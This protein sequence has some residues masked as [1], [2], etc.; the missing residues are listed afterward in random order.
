MLQTGVLV[1]IDSM[2]RPHKRH[3]AV[4]N[5]TRRPYAENGN[6]RILDSEIALTICGHTMSNFFDATNTGLLDT[7]GGVWS[8][9][10]EG[11]YAG[12]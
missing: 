4:V 10:C 5:R 2:T 1:E 11:C 9:K 7:S 3:R 6:V 12:V 8:T